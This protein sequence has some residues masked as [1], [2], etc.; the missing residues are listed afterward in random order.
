MTPALLDKFKSSID[1]FLMEFKDYD[2]NDVDD[3]L[4]Q[5]ALSAHHLTVDDIKKDYLIGVVKES[6]SK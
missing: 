1:K 5:E 6:N 3:N 4:I 2:L